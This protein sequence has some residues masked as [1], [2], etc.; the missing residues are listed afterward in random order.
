MGSQVICCVALCLLG[1]GTV[2]GR[3]TQTPKYLFKVEGRDVTLKCEQEF[4][5]DA[6]YWYRQDP[7]QGLRLIYYSQVVKDVQ[8]GDIAEGYSASR[9]KKS[10]FPLTL[11]STQKNQTALY[12]CATNID[13]VKQSHLP[14]AH[15]CGPSPASPPGAGAFLFLVPWSAPF[16]PA[17]PGSHSSYYNGARCGIGAVTIQRST[18]LMFKIT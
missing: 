1:A 8:K 18:E 5:Y 14:S 3:V 6:M 7:G 2:D 11:T 13:T 17:Q 15:K 4:G 10:L 9:E 12:L 16:L